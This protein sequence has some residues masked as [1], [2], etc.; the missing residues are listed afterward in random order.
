M[1]QCFLYGNGGQRLNFDVKTYASAEAL[2]GA[3]AR[4]NT[5]GVVTSQAMPGYAFAA[6]QPGLTY[7]DKDMLNGVTLGKG[8]ISGNG[9]VTGQTAANP[10]L[11][12]EEYLPV[13]N[14]VEYR[15]KYTVSAAKSM[16]L[17]I[18]EY[19][20]GNK[21]KQRLSLVA[22][23][24]GTEQSGVYIPSSEDVVSVRVSWRTFPNTTYTMAFLEHEAKTS[25][26]ESGTVWIVTGAE[27]TTAF[28]AVV[29][30]PIR[31]YPVAV[32]QYSDGVWAEREAYVY[33]GGAWTQIH[34][35]V[36]TQ[37]QYEALIATLSEVYEN[38]DSE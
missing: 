37:A 25:N 3:A 13:K 9:V 16:W 11:Y 10:E 20:S 4:E 33:Q 17:V 14:G 32:R 23:V 24:T 34:G 19:T 27:S 21:F 29:R 2:Q 8:Y 35:D 6:T 30:N 22:S 28:D 18:A 15:W 26:V 1:G 5:I 7:T 36:S 12:T 38:A 31:V